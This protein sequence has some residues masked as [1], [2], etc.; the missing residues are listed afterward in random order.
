M[1]TAIVL[2]LLMCAGASAAPVSAQTSRA[3]QLRV[4]VFDPSGAVIP[5]A[6]VRVSG[7]E[8]RTRTVVRAD[9]PTDA[10]GV[11]AAD[12]LTP[13]RYDIEVTFPGF[14]TAVVTGVRVRAGDGNRREITMAIEKVDESVAVGRDPAAAAADPNSGRFDTVLSKD[15]IDA[16]PDD[17]DEMQ[18]VLEDMA[19]PGATIRVDGFRGGR[20]PP[21]SQI[22]S[23]RFSRD[24]FAAEHHGGGMIHV[25]ISTQPGMGPLSG[26]LDFTFR[27]DAL[28]ARNAFQADKGDEQTQRYGLNLSGTL[29]TETTSF[30]LAAGGV[31]SFD[32][33]NVFATT[34]DGPVTGVARQVNDNI[35]F[36]GRIDHAWSD[37]HTLRANVLVN[38]TDATSG[39]GDFNLFDRGLTTRRQNGTLRLSDSGAIGKS[40]FNETRLE[41]SR[42]SMDLTPAVDAPTIDVLDAFVAGGAQRRGGRDTT[43]LEFATNVDYAVG[44]HSLRAGLLLESGWYRSDIETNYL[45]RFTFASLDDYAAGRPAAYTQRVGDPLV[46]YSQWQLGLFVQDD[47]R[48]RQN[49]TISV[50]V[51][52]E[53]QANLGDRL[54]LSPRLGMTWSPFKSGRTTVRGSFGVFHDWLEAQVYEQTLQVDGL[55]QQEIVV[56]NPG[57]P[58]Y[59][60]GGS[61]QIVLPA[62]RYVLAGDLSMPYSVRASVGVQQRILPALG[63]NVLYAFSRGYDRFRGRNINAPDPGLGGARPDSA[64][65][66]ITQVESSGGE[67]RHMVHAGLS[68]M[69]PASRTFMFLNYTLN[70]TENDS[71]GA[72]GL[73]ADNHDL[74]AEWAPA[75]MPRHN[76]NLNV[77][78]VFFGRLAVGLNGFA[79]SGVFYN[80]TTGR[81][82]NGD[83][84]FNDRPDGV[85]RNSGRAEPTFDFGGRLAYT[86]GFGKRPAG[87]GG[88]PA[89]APARIMVRAG[90]DGGV[91]VFGGGAGADDSRY[92]I[93]LFLS[94]S[95]LLNTVNPIGYS[96][97]MTSPVFGQPTGA[98]P[99]RRIDLGVR[100]G[101]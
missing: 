60:A 36:T 43:S 98:A 85:G 58:D 20:L 48:A 65:G 8:E 99:A 29:K 52:Q 32:A 97:V 55:R 46:E 27:D 47:W 30:S 22:R 75:P 84:V 74:A 88:G 86:I 78:R 49:L 96:G 50:G 62:S 100:F 70:H 34:L 95:N 54:N 69:V 63:A 91:S 15:Q 90:G 18:K 14:E 80:I 12:G 66:N 13:G 87:E 92:R 25:D 76:L 93:E 39:V 37:S 21:K 101:F 79:R 4:V 45:G 77:S 67:R 82:D 59:L 9:L 51:R 40:I 26:G 64:F 73:P 3:G 16:L 19:G 2:L 5:G 7:A 83:T 61:D 23:I 94:A 72:F 71:A 42:G 35:S 17:P 24:P 1:R 57:Y 89:G 41:I 28:N 56:R 31:S 11:A 6:L 38:D 33:A 44:R 68:Y 81:D 53:M 10:R